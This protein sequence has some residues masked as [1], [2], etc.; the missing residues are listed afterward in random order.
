MEPKAGDDLLLQ[1]SAKSPFIIVEKKVMGERGANR[2]INLI[3]T[4]TQV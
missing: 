3:V 1:G 4:N 2:I